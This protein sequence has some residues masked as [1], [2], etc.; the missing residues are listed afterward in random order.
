LTEVLEIAKKDGRWTE[1]PS[2]AETI[3]TQKLKENLC[4]CPHCD[5]HF[6]LGARDRIEIL[7]DVGSFM[8]IEH[9]ITG[10]EGKSQ[11]ADEAIRTGESSI[12]GLPCVLGIMDFTHK[13][14]S[15][16]VT[17]GETI[18]N[19]MNHG[20]VRKLPLV[21][22]C[23]SGGSGCRKAFGACSRCC[24]RCTPGRKRRKCQ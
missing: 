7:C 3:I 13:G 1:C 24:V 22:F 8:E 5:Y 6:R 20:R 19:M 10:P 23:A 18:I 11:G 2:C 9:L 15:M 14:G 16:G 21:V 17:V 4:V 12:N